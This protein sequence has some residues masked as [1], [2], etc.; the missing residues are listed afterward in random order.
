MKGLKKLFQ[1][2]APYILSGYLG[3]YLFIVGYTLRI[4]YRREQMES[5]PWIIACVIGF[6]VGIAFLANAYGSKEVQMQMSPWQ[7]GKFFL[8][9]F[10]VSSYSSLV[11]DK[12]LLTIFPPDPTILLGGFACALLMMGLRFFLAGS[13]PSKTEKV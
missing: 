13:S 11:K 4:D 10:C 2:T 7:I 8:I 1:L 3:W 6:L 9:P 12:G 5:Q